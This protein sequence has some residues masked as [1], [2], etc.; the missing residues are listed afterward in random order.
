MHRGV[1]YVNIFSYKL[2][3][4]LCRDNYKI[5]IRSRPCSKT[6]HERISPSATP[7]PTPP[8]EIHTKRHRA[9]PGHL[10]VFHQL[11]QPLL[12][13]E[14]VGHN[15]LQGQITRSGR[16][17]TLRRKPTG[18]AEGAASNSTPS[19]TSLA[20]PGRD[21][22]CGL[23]KWTRCR[24]PGVEG[25]HPGEEDRH[26]EEE[27]CHPEEEDHHPREKDQH[28]GEEDIDPG[29]ESR[30]RAL[31]GLAAARRESGRTG[32]HST[33]PCGGSTKRT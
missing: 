17:S 21:R 28:P 13:H 29:E 24:H 12:L 27:N 4:V 33:K 6:P 9:P 3:I 5:K 32:L 19:N 11:R 15:A 22:R 26:P 1:E 8:L 20:T 2:Y 10:A 14:P 25:R 16:A 31:A 23:V 30:P 7:T 18:L